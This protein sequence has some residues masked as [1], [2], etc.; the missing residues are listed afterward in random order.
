[1]LSDCER[2]A[3][4]AFADTIVPG[5]KRFP[6]DRAIAGVSEDFG[7]VEAGALTVLADPATGIEDGITLM[8]Q[9]LDAEAGE[10]W[11]RPETVFADLPYE[12][13]RLLVTRLTASG[14]QMR[15][16]WFLLALFAYMAYDSAPHLDT[17]D[18]VVS[19]KSGLTA[20]GFTGPNSDGRWGTTPAGY[21]R[22][23]ASLHPGTDENGNLG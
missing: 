8:A 3:L 2:L 10:M 5:C 15:D 6:G 11:G 16:F 12:Q 7:A 17:A 4:E 9:M 20:M 21:G 23:M 19:E 14:T 1:M 18:A 13:R 22:P